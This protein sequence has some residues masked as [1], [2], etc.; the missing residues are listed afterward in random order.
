MRM[1]Q[2]L[3]TFLPIL[4]VALAVQVLAPIS[5]AFAM[6]MTA[7]DQ[8]WPGA[9]CR[10]DLDLPSQKD[11]DSSHGCDDGCPLCCVAA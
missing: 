7:A 4:F 11:D 9:I 10:H 5:A 1:R 6:A 8:A 3:R 2:R